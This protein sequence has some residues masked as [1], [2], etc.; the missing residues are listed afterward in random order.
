M[1]DKKNSK[2]IILPICLLFSF[3]LLGL[4][5][6]CQPTYRPKVAL[7][8]G[9]G[10]A[11]GAATIGV[12][13]YV[14]KA[15]VP[16]DLI[17]GTSIGSVIGGLYS[18]G[19]KADQIDSIFRAQQWSDYVLSDWQLISP[20][21]IKNLKQDLNDNDVLGLVSGEKVVTKLDELLEHRDCFFDELP[22]PFRCIAVNVDDF[23]EVCLD[24]GNMAK[25]IRASMSFPFVFSSVKMN[26]K[27]LVDGG[28]LNN[29]PVDVARNLGADIVIAVDISTKSLFGKESSRESFKDRGLKAVLT[30][31]FKQP[32]QEKYKANCEDA[33]LLIRPDVDGFSIISFR[34]KDIDQLV[35]NGEVAGL[36]AFDSLQS[37]AIRARR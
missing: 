28:M 22:I 12:L 29:L 11:K 27:E 34:K 7:V 14:E 4:F 16:I 32:D 10:G 37:I 21:T 2:L 24:N 19:Y 36:E 8:L 9:G 30:W 26:D 31:I 33:D 5:I 17:V 20:S 13:K 35:R 25:C 18:V 1:K 23:T 3:I 6:S 15:G